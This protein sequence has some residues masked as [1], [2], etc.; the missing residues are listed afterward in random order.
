MTDEHDGKMLT[1]PSLCSGSIFKLL[2]IS[3]ENLQEERSGRSLRNKS[4]HDGKMS[5]RPVLQTCQ[6][7]EIPYDDFH[8]IRSLVIWIFDPQLSRIETDEIPM[9]PTQTN[10]GDWSNQ[11]FSKWII[12]QT[13]HPA[14]PDCMLDDVNHGC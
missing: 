13:I 11:A 3:V 5:D 12:H 10:V 2:C 9:E 1:S 4:C 6:G 8:V 14:R 7:G